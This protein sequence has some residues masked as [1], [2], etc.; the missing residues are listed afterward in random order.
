MRVAAH[1][2][3]G[4]YFVNDKRVYNAVSS[5]KSIL[6]SGETIAISITDAYQSTYHGQIGHHPA[7]NN[8]S[9]ADPW[10][11]GKPYNWTKE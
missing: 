5:M 9:V 11:I 2:S 10:P 7:F 8:I 4:H 6:G 1:E 3:L